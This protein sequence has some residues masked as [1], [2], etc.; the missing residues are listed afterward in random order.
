M[1]AEIIHAFNELGLPLVIVGDGPE[2]SHLQ[3]LAKNNVKLLGYQ[4]DDVV[5]A[6]MNHAKAFVYM[7][8]EDFGIAMVEAQAAGCPIIAYGKGGAAEIVQDGET[9]ILFQEQSSRSLIEAVL[10]SQKTNF[11]SRASRENSLRFSSKRFQEEFQRY[12]ESKIT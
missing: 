9:G 12:M 3:K 5:A 2:M 10:R 11:S 7:A 1:T 6:L 4:P 8:V